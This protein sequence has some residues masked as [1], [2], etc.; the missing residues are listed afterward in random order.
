MFPYLVIN[1]TSLFFHNHRFE[2]PATKKN[3]T[4]RIEEWA[5]EIPPPPL[6]KQ[7][8]SATG[9][10]TS[11]SVS[12]KAYPND[13]KTAAASITAST[14]STSCAIVVDSTTEVLSKKPAR[15]TKRWAEDLKFD[16]D[17]SGNEGTV[18]NLRYEGLADD[19][20]DTL[21]W[22]Y[23]VLSPVKVTVAAQINKV[24]PWRVFE[25][26]ITLLLICISLSQRSLDVRPGITVPVHVKK[27]F[28]RQSNKGLPDGALNDGRWAMIFV[29]TFLRYVASTK[30]DAWTITKRNTIL[31]LQAIWNVV[32]SGCAEDQRMKIKHLVEPYNAVYDVVCR[33]VMPLL[34]ISTNYF[35]S[36]QRAAEWQ[37]SIG[38]NALAVLGNFMDASHLET[39]EERQKVAKKLLN[40]DCYIYLKTKDIEED[41]VVTMVHKTTISTPA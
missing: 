30:E 5:Q 35:Q 9:S 38:T 10:H 1:A 29:P 4:N 31:A 15:G 19:E 21:E 37:S 18:S 14:N 13:M 32:Y 2:T 7:R 23:A 26:L 40:Y 8:T 36:V 24:S 16:A 27:P 22:A 34:T 25:L 20:D 28:K 41:E 11:R 33:F 3:I 17:D 12:S 39:T 6:K